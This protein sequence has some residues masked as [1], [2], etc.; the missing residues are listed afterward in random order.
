MSLTSGTKL[1]PYEVV[2]PLGAGGLGEVFAEAYVV[3]GVEVGELRPP[4]SRLRSLGQK[5]GLA[6]LRLGKQ[7][8]ELHH[9]SQ[10]RQRGI[11]LQAGVGAKVPSDRTLDRL[12]RQLFLPTE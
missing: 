1:G 3:T 7:L 12:H 6:F 8:I 4:G 5:I 9:A 10:L 2:A 11:V